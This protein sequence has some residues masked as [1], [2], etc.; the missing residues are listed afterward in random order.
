MGLAKKN[1]S[2]I[3]LSIGDGANDVPMIMEAHIGVGVRGK[4][5]TQAVRSADY[6]LS[7]FF[8]LHRLLMVHGRLGYRRVSWLVC[9]YFYK[10]IVLVFTEIF[11]SLENGFSGQIFFADWLQTLYNA[12]WSS[13]ACLAAYSLE[14]DVNDQYVYWY[15]QVYRAG[16]KGVYF[17]FKVFWR[18]IILSIWHGSTCYF[19]TVYVSAPRILSA[20]TKFYVACYYI[21]IVGP[22]GLDGHDAFALVYLERRFLSH[23]EHDH[24]QAV[25]RDGVLELAGGDHQY[26][27]PPLLLHFGH[28]RQHSPHR[29]DFPAGNQRTVLRN[30]VFRKSLDC[31][32]RATHDCAPTG[33]DVYALPEDFLPDPD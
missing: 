6:A 17:N 7:Q 29:R 19:G 21:G 12:L 18:W 10:N 5:G 22:D 3:T 13:W 9:Y 2:W 28:R 31:P 14:Q 30:A 33:H 1:G 8:Y 23:H 27:L 11:F 24:G 16:Q 32:S 20:L 26:R 15:P 25:H 4:E